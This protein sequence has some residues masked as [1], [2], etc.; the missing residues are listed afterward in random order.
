M[1]RFTTKSAIGLAA[2]LAV[3]TASA[4]AADLTVKFD[5]AKQIAAITNN[6][7]ANVSVVYFVGDDGRLYDITTKIAKGATANVAMRHG[8]PD[9]VA[10]AVC[11]MS[12][13]PLNF[14]RSADGS[15]HLSVL[16]Q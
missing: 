16:T 2:M 3:G 10:E 15:Y 7:A 11:S 5:K 6:V 12:N 8:I 14:P 13:P 1:R 4:L 9:R